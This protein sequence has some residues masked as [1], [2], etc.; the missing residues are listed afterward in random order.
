MANPEL[1]VIRTAILKAMREYMDARR[2]HK[3]EAGVKLLN[4]INY[5]KKRK[6]EMQYGGKE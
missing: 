6:D 2:G 4:L 5:Y 3:L 1:R